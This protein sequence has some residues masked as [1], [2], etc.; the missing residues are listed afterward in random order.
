MTSENQTVTYFLFLATN[1]EW[2][3]EESDA[4]VFISY[5]WDLQSRVEEIRRLLEANNMPCWADI[6]PTLT[7]RGHSSMS[8]RSAHSIAHSIEGQPETLQSQIQ[9]TMKAA[10]V[11]ICCITPKY[12]QSDNCIKDLTLA[13]VLHKPILPIMM[14]FCPWPPD[15]APLQVRKILVKLTPIDLS[16]DKLF[17]Q[18]FHV[19][20]DKIRKIISPIAKWYHL[21]SNFL[22][23][24]II[25]CRCRNTTS[26]NMCTCK[27][28]KL[29]KWMW[30]L[31]KNDCC[32]S[33]LQCLHCLTSS[34]MHSVQLWVTNYHVS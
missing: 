21:L 24:N 25:L 28:M 4:K 14:R 16:N 34:M 18:N 6:S 7:Q 15:G 30:K 9:R 22:R 17:K 19:L 20:L 8:S 23:S 33:K 11:V 5:Q 2:I 12:M 32:F 27:L 13:E 10:L 31:N 26:S 1:T 3:K 29:L